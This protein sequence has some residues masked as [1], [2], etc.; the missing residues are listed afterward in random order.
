M[1]VACRRE[2]AP[3]VRGVDEGWLAASDDARWWSGLMEGNDERPQV[4][5]DKDCARFVHDLSHNPLD[6]KIIK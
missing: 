3:R 4:C 5:G 6:I 1:I 2:R